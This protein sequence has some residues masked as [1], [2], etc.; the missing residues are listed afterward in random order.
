MA[1]LVDG[2]K[3]F[4]C[5]SMLN[6]GARQSYLSL[7]SAYEHLK[8]WW[9]ASDDLAGSCQNEYELLMCVGTLGYPIEVHRQAATQV[10][11]FAM[12]I[13][14]VRASVADTA[15]LAT[16]MRS[17]QQVVPPEG[18]A[19]IEDLLV[20]VDP[21]APSASRLVANS[22]LIRE[23]YTSV[24]LCR[25]M[26]MFIGNKMRTALHAHALLAAAQPLPTEVAREDV[27]AQ[28]RRQYLGRAF[29]CGNCSFGPIDHFACGDL[30]SH[31]GEV[32]AGGA[33][34]NN[35]CPRCDWF[36]PSIEDWPKWNGR[37]PVQTEENKTT[38]NA[39]LKSGCLTA[40]SAEI[41][42]RIC[43][44]ARA[45]SQTGPGSDVHQ[46]C[47]K[48]AS[49]ET[50]TAADG[51]DHPVQILLALAIADDVPN[52]I[53]DGVPM[54]M[55]L[56]EVCARRAR[57]DLRCN[58]G[59]T[60]ESVVVVAARKKMCAFLGV[61]NVSAP[62]T[63]PLGTSEPLRDA[64]RESCCSDFALNHEAFDCKTWLKDVLT[65]WVHAISFVRRL[66]VVLS[67]RGGGWTQ[68]A[69]DMESGPDAFADVLRALTLQPSNRESLRSLLGIKSP[70]DAER[71]LAT[72]AAQAF[73]HSS[74][75]SRRTLADGGT[76]HEP[77]G[78]VR[79]TSTLRCICVDLRMAI[80]EERVAAKMKEWGKA[81]VSLTFQRALVADI[82]QYS[83]MMKGHAHSLD[84]PTFWGMW[85]AA[86]AGG[87]EKA[88]IF[89]SSCN[90]EFT[91]K[92]G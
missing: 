36:S 4:E 7:Q 81:G 29:Q 61:S 56:N 19:P 30:L 25:D 80:Y 62:Q 41:A 84:G 44:S 51:V 42:L 27:E 33:V 13:A 20:L 70:L 6:G 45:T 43:Y 11:P 35:H 87:H 31:N 53:F 57:S 39:E 8:D 59:T 21:D 1:S 16:A 77:L 91:N 10:D 34:I 64:V 82:D 49:W 38:G 9:E 89:L 69:K 68:L 2:G 71:V 92:H 55:L 58:A 83:Q 79:E 76:L 48:L 78:D 18:G 88:K 50:L 67:T 3:A 86:K 26:H 46:L 23:A 15:S 12:S 85:K 47:N 63:A 32:T 52:E 37:L 54:L 65:P 60:D 66:R 17:E 74:S 90:R 73:M 5:L 72:I 40:S 22:M 75:Q 24:V 28:M 14:R